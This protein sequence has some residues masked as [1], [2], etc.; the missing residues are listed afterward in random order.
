MNHESLQIKLSP[1]AESALVRN[2]KIGVLKRLHQNNMLT[3]A[4]LSKL[5]QMQTQ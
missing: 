5:I 1:E 2:I 4:Q 3:D